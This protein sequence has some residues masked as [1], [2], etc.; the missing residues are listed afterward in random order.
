MAKTKKEVTENQFENACDKYS[1]AISNGKDKE[2]L[3]KLFDEMI[4]H[5]KNDGGLLQ[6]FPC[7]IYINNDIIDLVKAKKIL[8]KNL[9]DLVLSL[10]NQ[11]EGNNDYIYDEN[12]APF[13]NYEAY[14]QACINIALNFV[15]LTGT[16]AFINSKYL[17]GLEKKMFDR[18]LDYMENSGKLVQDEMV[19]S[20][21]W[22]IL[23]R[24][25]KKE[26]Y[27][28]YTEEWLGSLDFADYEDYEKILYDMISSSSSFGM[29]ERE[30]EKK[31]YEYLTKYGLK[32]YYPFPKK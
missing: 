12:N 22:R 29:D 27:N 3:K 14:H 23:F 8:S 15:M 19:Y 25:Y 21:Q 5:F 11:L 6:L 1:N 10:S 2:S 18:D 13:I 32:D 7:D 24:H 9:F 26:V 16:T 28:L 20:C 31:T 30:K 17:Q 4:F